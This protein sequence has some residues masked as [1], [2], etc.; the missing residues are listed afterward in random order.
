MVIKL[1][2]Q[3]Q[4]VDGAILLAFESDWRHQ[5]NSHIALKIQTNIENECLQLVREK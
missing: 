1:D 2:G 3:T 4:L 5:I